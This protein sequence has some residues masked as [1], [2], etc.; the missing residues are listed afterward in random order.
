MGSDF[1]EYFQRRIC[2][3]YLFHGFDT[4]ISNSGCEKFTIETKYAWN[5]ELETS[6]FIAMN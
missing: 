1:R 5:I 3:C 4:I 6:L 2:R